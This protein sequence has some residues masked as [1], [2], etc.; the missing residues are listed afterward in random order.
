MA[1]AYWQCI[2]EVDSSAI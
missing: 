2:F 1:A